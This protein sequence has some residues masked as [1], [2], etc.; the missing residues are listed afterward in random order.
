MRLTIIFSEVQKVIVCAAVQVPDSLALPPPPPID[1]SRILS[2]MT[3][4]ESLPALE[5]MS[6][7]FHEV[8]STLVVVLIRSAVLTAAAAVIAI[9]DVCISPRSLLDYRAA[10]T[11][12]M[13]F[14]LKKQERAPPQCSEHSS[15]CS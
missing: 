6:G 4:D 13:G 11:A 15:L 10:Y 1:S 2:M 8:Q 9:L 12:M 7:T 3:I 14:F 5:S